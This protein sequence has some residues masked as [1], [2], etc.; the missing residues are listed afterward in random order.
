MKKKTIPIF[1]VCALI[2]V[3]VV[4]VGIVSLVRKYTPGTERQDLNTYYGISENDDV[5]IVLDREVDESKAKVIDGHIYLDYQFLH[6][7]LNER[8]YWDSNENIL[9]YAT[10]QDLISAETDSES[11][12]ITKASVDFGHVVVT[13][14]A[15]SAYIDLDFAQEYSDFTYTYVEDPKRI[16]ITSQWGSYETATVRMN[17]A[18]RVKGGIK[19]PILTN[20]GAKDE[21]EVIEAGDKWTRVMTSDGIIGYIRNRSLSN[22]Q[23]LLPHYKG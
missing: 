11:Y 13:A 21:V 6:D 8:F 5:A 7:K 18:I 23:T 22:T 1:I 19:S 2:V 15:D 4:I 14:T 9:L 16:I 3:V 17:S 20:I 10:P 12:L